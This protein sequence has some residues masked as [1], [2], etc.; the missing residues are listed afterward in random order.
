[1]HMAPLSSGIA[2]LNIKIDYY[3]LGKKFEIFQM[4]QNSLRQGPNKKYVGY[5]QVIVLT[6]QLCNPHI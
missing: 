6:L 1:M 3:I 4:D 2:M 5:V